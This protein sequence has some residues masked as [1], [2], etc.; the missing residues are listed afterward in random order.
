MLP[1][2][3]PTQ[4]CAL[5]KARPQQAACGVKRGRWEAEGYAADISSEGRVRKTDGD[6]CYR[7]A[8]PRPHR[9]P[10]MDIVGHDLG[11]GCLVA[12]IHVGPRP[13]VDSM[14][15]HHLQQRPG[16]RTARSTWRGRR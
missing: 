14:V 11:V 3:Y 16:A 12:Q 6:G 7:L 2:P 4:R 10:K 13:A 9:L 15:L 5:T 8:G 1:Y